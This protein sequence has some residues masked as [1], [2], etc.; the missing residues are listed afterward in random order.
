[1]QD[2]G[3]SVDEPAV[4]AALRRAERIALVLI[5]GAAIPVANTVQESP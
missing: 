5:R 4:A 3:E 2:E 1:M